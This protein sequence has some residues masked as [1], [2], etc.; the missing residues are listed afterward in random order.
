MSLYCVLSKGELGFYKDAKG[1]ASGGTH[2]GEPL[3]SLHKATSEV[4]SDYKKKKHVFKLQTQDGSEFLLQAKDEEEM[5]GWLEAVATSVGE[6]A[7]IARWGQTLPTTSST[8]E[9]NPKREAGER[10]ASGRRK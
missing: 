6:H 1:P 10:R 9:G 3:L 5:N 2:G 4:A 7:E 8:D